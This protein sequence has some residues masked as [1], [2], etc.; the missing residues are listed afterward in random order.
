[1]LRPRLTG[2]SSAAPLSWF[3]Q[4]GAPHLSDS[5][6]RQEEEWDENPHLGHQ[7]QW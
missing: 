2:G 5:G 1:M 3:E 7:A 4:E 6:R